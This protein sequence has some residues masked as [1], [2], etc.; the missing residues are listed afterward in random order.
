MIE[1]SNKI[2]NFCLYSDDKNHR[3][4]L[5]RIWDEKKSIPLFV[6]KYSGEADGIFLEL[7][8]TLITNNLY[9]LGYGGYYAVNLC[10]GIHSKTKEQK[11]KKTDKII[12]EYAKKASEIIIS[13][14]TLNTLTLKKREDEVL[15][16]LKSAKKKI[17]TVSDR[18]GRTNLHILTPCVRNGFFLTEYSTKEEI[19]TQI[20]AEKTEIIKSK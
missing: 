6:S 16:I 19:H 12:L 18:N 1:E 14:G 17:L 10:S 15:K 9:N 2:N 5:S 11:D 8:N 13:W 3:Y 7:T 4:L 20:K